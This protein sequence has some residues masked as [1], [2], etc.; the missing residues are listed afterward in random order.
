MD[1]IAHMSPDT[2]QISL[3]TLPQSADAQSAGVET[4]T[5]T[6]FNKYVVY[7]TKRSIRDNDI[8]NR[9]KKKNGQTQNTKTKLNKLKPPV[10]KGKYTKM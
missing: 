6:H 5:K 3:H 10:N 2:G 1:G 9:Y 7:S 8:S 4:D